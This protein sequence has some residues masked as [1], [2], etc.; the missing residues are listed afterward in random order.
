MKIKLFETSFI[1]ALICSSIVSLIILLPLSVAVVSH[2]GLKEAT[3]T[4]SMLMISGFSALTFALL[5]EK[6]PE[7]GGRN[8]QPEGF[9]A[10]AVMLGQP[11]D[12]ADHVASSPR[13]SPPTDRIFGAALRNANTFL[14]LGSAFFI[15]L[16]LPPVPA[17]LRYLNHLRRHYFTWSLT[18]YFLVIVV[19]R[20]SPSC[21]WP[22]PFHIHGQKS[23]EPTL[24]S[25]AAMPFWNGWS[26]T[27]CDLWAGVGSCSSAC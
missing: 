8:Y 4:Q 1:R 14:L 27:S 23:P 26:T 3:Y 5:V 10:L 6:K 13:S 20:L 21:W 12:R 22:P 7:I 18:Y 11:P 17:V 19:C 2:P 24:R 16:F 15:Y 25:Q 9:N